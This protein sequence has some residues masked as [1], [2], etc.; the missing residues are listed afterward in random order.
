MHF[1]TLTVYPGLCII[2]S[3]HAANPF[4][5]HVPAH[6]LSQDGSGLARPFLPVCSLVNSTF[7]TPW[8][9]IAFRMCVHPENDHVYAHPESNHVLGV[10]KVEEFT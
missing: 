7:A 8:Y 10:V 3:Y 6:L 5:C 2:F 4:V 1:V 9:V